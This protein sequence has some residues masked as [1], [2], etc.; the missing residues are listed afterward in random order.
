MKK[1][2]VAI[3]LFVVFLATLAFAETPAPFAKAKE[4]AL[5]MP[6]DSE[7]DYVWEFTKDGNGEQINYALVYLVKQKII[8]IARAPF[9]CGYIEETGE[10]KCVAFM[11]MG[12]KQVE[13]TQEQALKFCFG[14][15]KELVSAGA[16]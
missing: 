12:F 14:V 4:Y 11:G 15:F 10:I 3:T 8:I 16:I 7:G 5:K 2:I 6:M 1:Y 9:S 13:S